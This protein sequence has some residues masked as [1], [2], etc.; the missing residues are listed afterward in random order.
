[1]IVGDYIV[2]LLE[3]VSRFGYTKKHSGMSTSSEV[4]LVILLYVDIHKQVF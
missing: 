3:Y 4:S 2:I 1:M